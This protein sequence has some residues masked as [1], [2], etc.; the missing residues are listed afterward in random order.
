LT[1]EFRIHSSDLSTLAYAVLTHRNTLDIPLLT[2]LQSH[3]KER[4]RST[5]KETSNPKAPDWVLDLALPNSDDPESFQTPE[6]FMMCTLLDPVL[7]PTQGR[8]F[9]RLDPMQPL[10][11]ILRNSHFVE[12][13]AFEVW[14]SGAFRG[15]L[16][17]GQGC[18]LNDGVGEERRPKRRRLNVQA[19]KKALNGLLGGYGSSDDEEAGE[20]KNVLDLLGSYPGSDEDEGDNNDGKAGRF[21]VQPPGAEMETEDS[22]DETDINEASVVLDPAALLELV[23]RIPGIVGDADGEEIDWGDSDS[24]DEH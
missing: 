22:E 6:I 19:G 15:T 5:K 3:L 7:N 17:D 10:D 24:A 8:A 20:V 4:D 11:S 21:R 14:E 18:V 2:I 13:P 12:F 9:R 23:R 1:V 16:V